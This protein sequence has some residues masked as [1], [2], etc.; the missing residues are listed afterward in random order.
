MNNIHLII[1][2]VVLICI[3]F[4]YNYDIYITKKNNS[5]DNIN[6]KITEEEVTNIKI[7]DLKNNNVIND[8]MKVLENIPSELSQEDMLK[9][10]NKLNNLYQQSPSIND[11][12][13]KIKNDKSFTEYPYNTNYS[14]LVTNIITTLDNNYQKNIKSIKKNKKKKDKKVKFEDKQN[15]VIPPQPPM[16]TFNSIGQLTQYAPF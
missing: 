4:I 6:N 9:I 3:Y 10:V 7:K 11:F 14:S 8:T 1:I 15:I 12:N 13:E 16:E 5:I 2:L